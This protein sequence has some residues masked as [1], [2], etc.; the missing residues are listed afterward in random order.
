MGDRARAEPAA[1][2]KEGLAKNW[3]SPNPALPEKFFNLL[4]KG[5]PGEI[6]TPDHLVRSQVLY[7]AELRAQKHDV[8]SGDY[9][10]QRRRKKSVI[11]ALVAS[12]V[13][14]IRDFHGR[15]R[16]KGLDIRRETFHP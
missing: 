5:A 16:G 11:T 9:T 14:Y 7:P 4:I 12:Y 8:K 2:G 10:R 3:Q 15:G 13:K 1:N 6:R